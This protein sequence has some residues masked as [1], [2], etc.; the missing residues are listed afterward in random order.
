MLGVERVDVLFESLVGRDA[1]IDR[2]TNRFARS[3]FHGG[4]PSVVCLAGPKNFGPF[5][6]VPVIAKAAF[7]IGSD[8]CCHS[9]RSH[10]QALPPAASARSIRGPGWCR[11]EVRW[12]V[13]LNPRRSVQPPQATPTDRADADS[14]RPS[15]QGGRP[16]AG[17]PGCETGDDEQGERSL[18]GRMRY[19]KGCEAGQR[20][21]HAGAQSRRRVSRG[22]AAQ[23]R[24]SLAAWLSGWP[25]L[26]LGRGSLAA[27]LQQRD[28]A[29]LLR[30]AIG[31]LI[32]VGTPNKKGGPLRRRLELMLSLPVYFDFYTWSAMFVMVVTV[33]LVHVATVS[34]AHV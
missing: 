6:R 12:S 25:P 24:S 11:A 21:D 15:P 26:G 19:A 31:P 5:Q 22:P 28:N 34:L 1:G 2:A 16:A 29:R 10:R 14:P 13:G 3:G 20:R 30:A 17:T 18:A 4:G 8:R 9:R 27:R 23:D 7:D 32:E 33:S